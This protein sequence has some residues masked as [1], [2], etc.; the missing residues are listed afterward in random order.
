MKRNTLSDIQASVPIAVDAN[1]MPLRLPKG[2][3]ICAYRGEVWIT[4]EGMLDDVILGPGERF[5]VKGRELILASATRGNAFVFVVGPTHAPIAPNVTRR[6]SPRAAN[7][8]DKRGFAKRYGAGVIAKAVSA[9]ITPEP[10]PSHGVP[11]Q[12]AS[13]EIIAG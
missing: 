6:H 3:A 8:A 11:A 1:P 9:W 10:T 2:S 12:S 13:Q 4:Q 7:G 5:D